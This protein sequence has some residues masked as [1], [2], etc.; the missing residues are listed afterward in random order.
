M[1]RTLLTLLLAVIF[2]T[3]CETPS[4]LL[5]DPVN[6]SENSINEI[7]IEG[8]IY[9]YKFMPL[10][11]KSPLW[12]DSVLTMSQAIDGETGG[13]LIMEKYYISLDGDSIQI[14]ADLRVPPGAFQGTKTI[15]ITV[16]DEFAALHF[17]PKMAFQDTLKLT[18]GFK[19]LDLTN[20]TNGN[21]DFIFI[22]DDGTI[23]II[24]KNGLQVI[25]PQGIVR[26]YNAKL[27]HFSRYGWVR[28][29]FHP[30]FNNNINHE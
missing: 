17:Y 8:G 9:T 14:W 28:K 16:D 27:L 13:Q 11:P 2:I 4:D 3:G 12:Q 29:I 10:P 7:I 24:K 26:V 21:V 15:T 18:R 20:C 22:D 1:K 25:K 23:E 19:G 5:I 30:G 6:T